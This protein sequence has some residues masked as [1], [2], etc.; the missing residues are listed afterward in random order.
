MAEATVAMPLVMPRAGSED[1]TIV[2]GRGHHA[3]NPFL[4]PVQAPGGSLRC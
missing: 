1:Q 3:G 2:W 4:G